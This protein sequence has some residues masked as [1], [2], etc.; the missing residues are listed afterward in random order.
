MLSKFTWLCMQRWPSEESIQRIPQETP[1]LFLSGLQDE[2]VP[3]AHM[4]ELH[5]IACTSRRSFDEE[6]NHQSSLL[7]GSS[8]SSSKEHVFYDGPIDRTT[9]LSQHRVIKVFETGHHSASP[10]SVR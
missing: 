7:C 10:P 9:M 4:Q 2:V 8:R 1:M 5:R 3:S 6:D